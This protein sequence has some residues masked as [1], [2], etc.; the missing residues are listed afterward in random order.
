MV[1]ISRSICGVLLFIFFLSGPAR[2]QDA[3]PAPAAPPQAAPPIVNPGSPAAAPA[4]AAPAPAATFSLDDVEKLAKKLAKKTFESPRSPAVDFLKGISEGDWNRIRFKEEF[5]LWHDQAQP[6]EISFFHPGF[7]YNNAVTV[8]VVEG[9]QSRALSFSTDQFSYG[10]SGLEEKA[11]QSGLSFA[12]FQIHYSI[13]QPNHKDEVASFLG[14]TH[15]RAVAK[16]SGYGLTARGLVLNPATPEGEEFPYFRQFWLVKPEPGDPALTIYALLDSPSLT[17]AYRFVVKPGL[18]TVMEVTA[19]LY[20]R[21]GAVL[22]AKIGLAPA[23]SMYLYSEKENGS[24]QDYRPEVHNSDILLY[25]TGRTDWTRRPLSNPERLEVNGF[26]LRSPQGFGLMQQDNNFDHYQDI[27]ARFDLRP[28]LWVEPAG[29]WGPGRVELIEIPSPLDIHDNVMAFW[30]P[31]PPAAPAVPDAPPPDVPLVSVDYRL[32]WMAPGVMPHQLGKAV[33]TRLVRSPKG[34]AAWFLIDFESEE[35]NAI[36]SHMGLSSQ[37][38]TPA[39][40]PVLE[41]SL[42]KNPVTGGWRLQFK[43]Q[44]PQEN[45]MVQSLMSARGEQRSLRLRAFLKRGE[46]LPDPLTETWIYDLTY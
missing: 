18:S 2:A 43:M 44:M 3:A 35:L 38:E 42:I 10:D 33:A 23:G 21:V 12:G 1:N 40:T 4:D 29:E 25:T 22:P 28:S 24:R 20:Q 13:D 11:R 7:I 30:V 39:E 6:F 16:H 36:P 31:D 8:H 27:G 14:A 9:G 41:K 5:N 15:F 34:D 19:R 37:I 46:N 26:P 17:G 45:G 32:Y